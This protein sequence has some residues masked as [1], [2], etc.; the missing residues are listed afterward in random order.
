M[1]AFY[2]TAEKVL[3]IQCGNPV[4]RAVIK[5]DQLISERTL[6]S[7]RSLSTSKRSMKV[8]INKLTVMKIWYFGPASKPLLRWCKGFLQQQTWRRQ[9]KPPTST[10]G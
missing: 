8:V 5:E 2:A 7:R 4:V 3:Q 1:K 10:K 6:W 9:L